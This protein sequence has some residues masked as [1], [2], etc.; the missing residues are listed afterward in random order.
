VA[1]N[2]S[3]GYAGDG[4]P[5][6]AATLFYPTGVA[7]DNAGNLY[8][9]DQNNQRIR[10]VDANGIITTVAGNG[11]AGYAGDGGPA[12]SAAIDRPTGVSLDNAGGLYIAEYGGNRIRKV[13]VN[14][15]ITT[16][17]GNGIPGFAGDGGLATNGQVNV[18]ED[19]TLDSGGN[20]FIGDSNNARIRKV[21][22]TTSAL[23][24]ASVNVG[25]NSAAQTVTITNIGNAVLNISAI[26]ASNNFSVDQGSTTC[27][28]SS[29]VPVGA[30]CTV[31][32]LFA[33]T[34]GGSLVGTL[35]ITDNAVNAGAT[36]Q[37][38]LSGVGV[39][40]SP[41]TTSISAPATTYGA[42]AGVTV[43]VSSLQG[44]VTGDVSLTVDNG[45]PLAQPLV[46]GLTLF[47]ISA[48]GVGSHSL[49]ASYSAQ[50]NFGAS[51]ATGTLQINQATPT[52]SIGNIPGGAAYGGYFT[53]TY[54]Y[55]GDGTTSVTSSTTTTC[56]V[57]GGVVN[58]VG[59]GTCTL[60]A[61]SSATAN[62]TAANGSA[63]SFTVA[64]ATPTISIN[65]IPNNAV[66]GGSFRPTF[67]YTGDGTASATSST[68]ATCTVSS[69]LVRFVGAGTCALTAHATAGTNYL[70]VNGNPQS[71]SIAQAVTTIGV[72]NIP[73]GAKYRGSFTPTYSYIGD[74][75]P[76]VTSSTTATC[77]VSGGL[78]NFVGAGTCTLTAHATAG[79]NY[80]AATGNP[81]SFLIGQATPT[82]SINNIPTNAQFGGTF[83]PSYAYAGDGTT[84]VT[85]STATTCTVS[86][87]VVNFVG[88][89]TCTLT[90][91]ATATVNSAAATGS[92]QS[93]T[94]A[95][96][97]PTISIN[98]IPASAVL[99]GSFTLTYAYVGNGNTST[100]S[101]T[102]ST[103]T[104]V[105]KVNVK[106]LGAGTCTLTAHATATTDYAAATGNSQSFTIAQATTTISIK[107]I[108]TNAKKGGSFTPAYNYVGDGTPSATSST[109]NICTVSGN[110]VSF[111]ASGTCTL[112]A[113]ATAGTNYAATTG[114]P[115]SFTI[116]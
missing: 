103:C 18:P 100:T 101:S 43:S 58:F 99:G 15:T 17:A 49:S 60:T 37:V 90:A 96:A 22:V 61:H 53:P 97:T 84:S 9:A 11:T 20:L 75:T 83:A 91:R 25:Q 71:F 26:A 88:L 98:N 74:G 67:A 65:N 1:G 70:A 39:V 4:G 59:A 47:S 87:I 10:K 46:S 42:A 54:T 111:V 112:T 108:P 41:T 55:A 29:S 50:G 13:D 3:L 19:V 33:P 81:Q 105:M 28:T 6:T 95:Q 52:I 68:T 107:N 30:S 23:T 89:G 35:T 40:A 31:G 45:A 72:N 38:Q 94:I 76:S 36:Q 32:T 79:T 24:F 77:T 93:F 116:K 106:F 80:A 51:S 85:S 64:Q 109:L 82:I 115:Q 2:G 7:L 62:Y 48:L 12:T 14:G 113:Q 27:S 57:S 86:G 16:V 69:G 102:P 92:P 34:T 110:I 73:S 78:V 8:I 104:V 63:Q 44:T 114:T 66:F 56:T 5:A 21:D